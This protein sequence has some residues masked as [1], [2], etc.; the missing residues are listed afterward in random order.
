MTFPLV[1]LTLARRA[2]IIAKEPNI[3]SRMPDTA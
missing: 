2:G 3:V 1:V